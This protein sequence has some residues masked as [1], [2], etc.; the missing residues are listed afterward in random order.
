MKPFFK[1]QAG[2]SSFESLKPEEPQEERRIAGLWG[3]MAIGQDNK[4]E[5]DHPL[6]SDRPQ[7]CSDKC[8]RTSNGVACGVPGV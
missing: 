3:N 1:D 8:P 5:V 2:M 7:G 6:G 4:A